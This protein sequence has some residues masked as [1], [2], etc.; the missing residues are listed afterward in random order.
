MVS[1]GGIGDLLLT[2]PLLRSL[3]RAWPESTLETYVQKGREIAFEGNPDIDRILTTR[4]RHGARSYLDFLMTCGGRYDLAVSVRRSNRQVLFAR[5][6]GRKA[7]SLLAQ[8][9]T[10]YVWQR[11][12]LSH[13]VWS[14]PDRHVA[15]DILALCEPLG[16]APCYETVPPYHPESDARLAARLPFDHFR[17]P[18]VL[19]HTYPR[20]PYKQWIPSAWQTV[21]RYVAQ[22][23]LRVIFT[24]GNDPKEVAYV[25][26]LA[27]GMPVPVVNLAGK[28]SMA[29]TAALLKPCR[30]CIAPDTAMAHLS[31]AVKAPTIALFGHARTLTTYMPYYEGYH[32]DPVEQPEPGVYVRGPVTAICGTCSCMNG[33]PLVCEKNTQSIGPCMKALPPESVIRCIQRVGRLG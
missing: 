13:Y 3:R 24:G 1:Y 30:C 18:Y 20:N 8:R 12:V 26:E 31:A 9:F 6:A 25:N 2:T 11:I 7:I 23:G 32:L 28:L 29:D 21:V 22:Q 16:I 10:D 27:Q 19:I 33:A 14:S 5:W 15:L 4:R 17:E